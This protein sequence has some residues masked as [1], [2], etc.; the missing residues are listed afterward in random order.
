[1]WRQTGVGLYRAVPFPAHD[2]DER[3]H[4]YTQTAAPSDPTPF[5]NAWKTGAALSNEEL[6]DQARRVLNARE[7][8][9]RRPM[10]RPA[11]EAT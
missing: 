2:G 9:A 1:M 5:N 7:V 10:P 6:A 3:E 4:E 8:A 11:V